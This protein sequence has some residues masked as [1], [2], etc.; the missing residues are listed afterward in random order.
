[1]GTAE[2]IAACKT[3]ACNPFCII[4][5]IVVCVLIAAWYVRGRK[6]TTPPKKPEPKSQ[7][8]NTEEIIDDLIE[9]INTLNA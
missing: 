4:G 9:Q 3:L 2:T 6:S 7:S 1:M 5:F 8:N